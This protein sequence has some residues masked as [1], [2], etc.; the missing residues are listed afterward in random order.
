MK[1]ENEWPDHTLGHFLSDKNIW[2]DSTF[3]NS[4]KIS[5]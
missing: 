1:A 4:D 3:I 5:S 2:N